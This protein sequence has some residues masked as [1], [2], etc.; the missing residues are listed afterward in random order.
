MTKE[1]RGRKDREGEKSEIFNKELENMKKK[2]VKK[3]KVIEMKNSVV[4]NNSRLNYTEEQFNE[5]K[6]RVVENTEATQ[7]Q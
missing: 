3:N 4:G 7:I 5:L 1:L 6:I 2:Q